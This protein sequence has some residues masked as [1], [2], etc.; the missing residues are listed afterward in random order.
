MSSIL[1][2][3]DQ[4]VLEDLIC[5]ELPTLGHRLKDLGMT[6][7]ITLSWFLTVFLTVLPY[8]TAV[9]VID[10]FFCQGARVIFQLTLKIL[11][12]CE[13]VRLAINFYKL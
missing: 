1:F 4:G 6:Q 7:M 11:S 13:K 2:Q 9:Y 5:K 8:Q 12:K 10:G 3:V